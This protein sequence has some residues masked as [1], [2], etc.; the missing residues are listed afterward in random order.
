VAPVLGLAE[1]P[2]HPHAV[3]RNAFIE[4]GG[5]IQP[6]PAP[7]FGRSATGHPAPPPRPGADTDRVLADLGL[8]AG[9]V[10]DLRANGAIA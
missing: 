5:I 7:R 4:V 8:S 9:E 3:A 1:A 10:Q 6:A 2:R